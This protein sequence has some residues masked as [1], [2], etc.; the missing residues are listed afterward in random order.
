MASVASLSRTTSAASS[1]SAA[2]VVRHD[3]ARMTDA[4]TPTTHS[5]L[6]TVSSK[7]SAYTITDSDTVI[8]GNTSTAGFTL[9]LPTAVGRTGRRFLIK[10]IGGN[11]PLTIASNGGTIDSAST[12][13]ISMNYGF[14]EVVSDGTNWMVTGGK[15]DP[16]IVSLGNV[17][18]G[19]TLTIDA[20]AATVYRATAT[21]AGFTLAVP[22]NPIDGD[23]INVEVLASVSTSMTIH[24]SILLTTG[25]TT[26]IAIASGKRWFG[27]L[28]YVTGVGWFLLASTVQS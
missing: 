25:V 13:Q 26:P 17:A 7:T 6:D 27:G 20:S 15:V 23:Q 24:A 5:H 14:R 12:E 18:N 28:R 10:K 22:T 21:G 16:V 4:R 3:D 11:N 2:D 8:I 1:A 9:T 19:G